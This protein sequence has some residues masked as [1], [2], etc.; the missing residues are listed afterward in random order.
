MWNF[1]CS[2]YYAIMTYKKFI[3]KRFVGADII[4]PLWMGSFICL[5]DICIEPS[6]R[7]RFACLTTAEGDAVSQREPVPS[8][9]FADISPHCG[10]SPS[11]TPCQRG[12]H[13]LTGTMTLC[14]FVTSP[15]T[16]GSHPGLWYSA[17]APFFYFLVFSASKMQKSACT[18]SS[19][20][21]LLRISHVSTGDGCHSRL[22]P[23]WL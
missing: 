10:E 3:A 9:S 5:T 6:V 22:Y 4:R 11:F 23:L 14:H 18:I 15:Y 20:P 16:V 2:Y 1:L 19:L 7:L 12:L 13:F 21:P 8:V 17:A